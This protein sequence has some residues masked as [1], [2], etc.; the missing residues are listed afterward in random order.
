MKNNKIKRSFALLAAVIII[1]VLIFLVISFYGN[2]LTHKHMR[3]EADAYMKEHFPGITYEITETRYIPKLNSCR[4]TVLDK[5]HNHKFTILYYTKSGEM[6]DSYYWETCE[7]IDNKYA[8]I[9]D[10]ME[11]DIQKTLP[12]KDAYLEIYIDCDSKNMHLDMEFQPQQN[13]VPVTLFYH[14]KEKETVP[15]SM[16]EFEKIL[17]ILQPLPDKFHVHVDT[18]R[19]YNIEVSIHKLEDKD[20]LQKALDKRNTSI[21]DLNQ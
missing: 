8:S 11:Q 3:K 4:I 6:D 5:D 15:I 9:A 19:V 12:E 21:K 13:D 7:F 20:Y 2:P 17:E 1:I 18:I 14:S 10:M 16:E